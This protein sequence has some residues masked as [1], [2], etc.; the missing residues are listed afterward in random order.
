M[1]QNA[2]RA[3]ARLRAKSQLTIPES[4]VAAIGIGEG[5]RFLVEVAPED[6]D[7][8]RLHRIRSSYAGALRDVFGDP[9]AYL[10]EERASWNADDRSAPSRSR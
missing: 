3:E 8:I 4:V 10:E 7:L 1:T 2:V 6:P 5:D 9:H